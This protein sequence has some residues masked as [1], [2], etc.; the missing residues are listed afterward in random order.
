MLALLPACAGSDKPYATSVGVLQ[1]GATITVKARQADVS[2]YKPKIGD[3]TDRFTIAATALGGPTPP[4]PP[5]SRPAGNGVVVLAP[6]PLRSLLI[7]APEK[8]NVLVDTAGGNVS[9]TDISGSADVHTGDGNITVMVSGYA[10]AR[11]DHG[12]VNVTMGSL[13]W[14][15]TLKFSATRGDVVVYVNE[16]AHFHVRMRTL[17]GVLFTDFAGLR[18][19][20]N[21]KAETIDA[22]VN[23]G[24]PHTLELESGAGQVRLLRLTP[25]A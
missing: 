20:S 22:Q 19:S 14:P 21:G 23:G 17:D 1:P 24:G 13:D 9:V 15:G 8:V 3:P 11:S 2:I 4:P 5:S 16:N 7:R 18:G 25:Q 12:N 10:Q 6:N